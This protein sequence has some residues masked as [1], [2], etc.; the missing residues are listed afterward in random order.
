MLVTLRKINHWR[1][2][3]HSANSTK[4][5]GMHDLRLYSPGQGWIHSAW[6]LIQ[7]PIFFLKQ[8]DKK[9]H[10]IREKSFSILWYGSLKNMDLKVL[11]SQDLNKPLSTKVK[12]REKEGPSEEVPW[13]RRGP[14]HDIMLLVSKIPSYPLETGVGH[15]VFQGFK[16]KMLWKEQTQSTVSL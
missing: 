5:P 11:E 4:V 10:Y 15:V 8:T 2:Q 3:T 12:E 16:A 1:W 9:R 13:Y 6:P 14:H 7:P